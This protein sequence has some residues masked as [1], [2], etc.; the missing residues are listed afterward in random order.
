MYAC[1]PVVS[2]SL[3]PHGLWSTRIL[4]PWGY[5]GN[6]TRVGCHFL[7]QGIFL[8]QGSNL[9]LL[10]CQVDSLPLSYLGSPNNQVRNWASLVALTIKNPPALAGDLGQEDPLE[11]GM[12]TDSR[13]LAWR[14]PWREKPS[15]LQSM[16]SQRVRR[17]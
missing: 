4:C 7:L 15:G 14:I 10:H 1:L 6:N 13:I 2:D 9:R 17:D 16:R 3:Q 5:P 8:T 12:A 11:K